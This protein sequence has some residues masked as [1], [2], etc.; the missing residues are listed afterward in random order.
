MTQ[1]TVVAQI[2]QTLDVHGHRT[3]KI[4]FHDIVAVDCFTDLDDFGIGELVHATRDRNANLG[5]DL[6][7][8]LV[9]DPV[10]ILQRNNYALIRRDIDASNTCHVCSPS[11]SANHHGW[12]L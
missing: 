5:A 6:L 2:H 1:A 10:D 4:T 8:E 12:R 3:A 9:A 7:G 11:F